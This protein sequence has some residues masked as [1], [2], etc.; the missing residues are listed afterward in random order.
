LQDNA[1]TQLLRLRAG[2]VNKKL[3]IDL[4]GFLLIALV[5]VVGYKLSPILLPKADLSVFP[6]AH[7][8]LQQQACGVDLPGGG[9]V[10]LAMGTKPI[11]LVKPFR[12]EVKVTGVDPRLVEID[13]EGVDMKMGL[14]RPQLQNEGSGVFA[15]PVTLPICVT[16]LM[17][18]Q[19]TVLLELG[20][21]SVAIPYRFMTGTHE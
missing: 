4:I 20:D 14:N 8:D 18:W 1:A 7:C 3:L 16:G 21:K 12:V 2:L 9:R 17:E 13:F 10:E 11:P 6:D 5:V 19:A 15:T